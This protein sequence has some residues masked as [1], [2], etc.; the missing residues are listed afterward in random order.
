MSNKAR[1]LSRSPAAWRAY[2]ALHSKVEKY[3]APAVN[4]PME[5][6]APEETPNLETTPTAETHTE[7]EIDLR[8][9]RYKDSQS[10]YQGEKEVV[11]DISHLTKA[12]GKTVVLDD[13]SLQV[14]KGEIVGLIGKNGAGK[15]T[16]VESALGLKP[17]NSG[18]VTIGGIDIKEQ[19]QKAK[20]LI[21]YSPSEPLAYDTM[22]GREYLGYIAAIYSMDATEAK[23]RAEKLTDALALPKNMRDKPFA[24]CSH[25]TQQKICLAAS[26]LH[27]PELWI[28]DEPTVGLDIIAYRALLKMMRT[29]A[30]EGH[31]V[32]IITHDM[33]LVSRVCDRIYVLSGEKIVQTET[34]DSNKLTD[35]LEEPQNI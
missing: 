13:V 16:C 7:D 9:G 1:F 2:V 15:S 31:A 19:P 14:C 24:L 32:F 5:E 34:R 33:E 30:D 18:K 3:N 22:T 17:F 29:Y 12:Y 10:A 11:L 4:K 28:L 35:L 23:E 27:K 6:K 21:G 20:Q 25:G 26:L 8:F